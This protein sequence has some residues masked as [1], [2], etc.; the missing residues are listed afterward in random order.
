MAGNVVYAL[1]TSFL[2]FY[3]TD[4]VGLSMGVVGTLI[5]VFKVFDGVSDFFGRMI[6]KTKP[7]M[8]KARSCIQL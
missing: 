7:K 8:G 6:G 1:L 3:L 2:T 4:S 5:A